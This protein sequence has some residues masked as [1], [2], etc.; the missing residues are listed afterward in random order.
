LVKYLDEIEKFYPHGEI[1]KLKDNGEF[2][3]LVQ[4][5]VDNQLIDVETIIDM[6]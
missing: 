1:Q 4:M 5:F 3:F 2:F 6:F